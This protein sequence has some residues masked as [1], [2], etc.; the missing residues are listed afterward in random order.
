MHDNGDGTTTGRFTIPTP[1]AAILRKTVQQMAAPSR[2]N[3]T[4]TQ[5]TCSDAAET[6][7]ETDLFG[8]ALPTEPITDIWGRV[9]SGASDGSAVPSSA[10][11]GRFTGGT[12]TG[13]SGAAGEEGGWAHQYGLALVELLEHLPTDRLHGKVAATIVVTIGY[14][15]LID[16]LGVARTDTG[17]EVSASQARRWACEAGIVP[18]ILNG[19]SLPLD[20]GRQQRFFTEA[21]RAALAGIYDECAAD[22]CDR[23]NAWCHLHHRHSWATGGTT[24]LA[25]AV[26]LCGFHHRLVHDPTYHH[27]IS[28]DSRGRHTVTYARR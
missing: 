18:V 25:D 24:N 16:G 4:G 22:G 14:Q 26:P 9:I 20:L 27:D 13:P 12:G 1:A 28:T 23:P 6:G 7:P 5:P 8:A 19:A 10:S 2:Q 3:G 15:H 17:H 11:T 21:Q